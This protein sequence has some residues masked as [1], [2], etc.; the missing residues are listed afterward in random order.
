MRLVAY[1]L[2]VITVVL[3]GICV[4]LYLDYNALLSNYATI[5]NYYQLLRQEHESLRSAHQALQSQ[6]NT[7]QR[8]YAELEN[9]HRQLKIDYETL[10]S[11]H[12]KLQ[13]QY[14]GLLESYVSLEERYSGLQS[15][16]NH[17]LEISLKVNSSLAEAVAALFKYCYI[18]YAFE[19]TLSLNEVTAVK[20]YVINAIV[21]AD[22]PFLSIQ[23]I[24]K[25]I[26]NNVRYVHDVPLLIPRW[27]TYDPKTK[28][29]Y[30]EFE[31][32]QNYVQTPKFTAE[33]GQGDCD[34]QAILAY[35]MIKYYFLFI[36]GED[37]DLLVAY[38]VMD[39]GIAHLAVFL[40]VQGGS[41][42][43]ID[44]AGAYLTSTSF[45]TITARRAYDELTTSL[46]D[47]QITGLL[48]G[49]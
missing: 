23:N 27:V 7:L 15:Q 39:N 22:N 12:Q 16:Y 21:Y 18:P 24:Y 40:P 37:N 11:A 36:R 17:L 6:Y 35:A 8:D 34:D 25:W 41:L 47:T 1:T 3:G 32:I 13:D 46:R 38:I 28:L 42:T 44:P 30:Y 45:G 5:T 19:R 10:S 31:E 14:R 33:Y 9:N 2:I 26:R 49:V 20:Q 43:I 4:N 29:C 48:T